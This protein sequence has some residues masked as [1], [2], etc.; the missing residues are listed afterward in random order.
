MVEGATGISVVIPCFNSR[1]TLSSL[2]VNL[3]SQLKR[4]SPKSFEIILV[5]DGSVDG[6]LEVAVDLENTYKYVKVIQLT[7]NFGQ[8]AALLA[9]ISKAKYPLLI[10]MDDDGQHLPS[11][12]PKM[13]EALV[14]DVDVVYG[15]AESEEHG[16]FRNLLSRLAKQFIFRLLRIKNAREISAFRVFRRNLLHDMDTTNMTNVMIDIVLHWST[17]RFT[18]VKVKMNHREIGSSNYT[19]F[20]LLK[21]S[22]MMITGYSTVPLR[23]ASLIGLLGF[24]LFSSAGIVVLLMSYFHQ[25]SVPGY[26]TIVFSVL[27]IGSIQILLLGIFGEYLGRIHE[28][29]MQKPGYVIREIEN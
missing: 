3:V 15:I 11:E 7:K 25:I 8:H 9:G 14:P 24:A 4:I 1:Q 10:T 12:L 23:I 13:I 17:N 16:W 20:K 26:T 22:S 21:V 5:I 19:I 2:V 27:I 6:T 29:S 18:S 28:R